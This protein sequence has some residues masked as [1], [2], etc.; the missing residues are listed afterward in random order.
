MPLDLKS[1]LNLP[2]T[3][4][5]MKANLPQR[6]PKRLEHWEAMGIY[7]RIREA[8]KGEPLYVLHDGPPYA[9]G[10]IH[11]GHALN[12]TLKDFIVKAQTMSGYDAPYV[13]GWDCHGLPIEIKVDDDLGRKKLEMDP[14]EVRD[15]CRKYADKYL[16]L[17]REQFKRLGVFGQWDNPYSTMTKQYESTVMETF[18]AFYEQGL[19]Y[20]GLKS[21]Y[22]CVHDKTALAEA[23]VEYEMH[24]SPSV[25]VRYPLT[26]DARKIDPALEGKKN[27]ATI[28]WTTTPWTLPASM[29]VTFAPNAEY[30]ALDTGEWIDIVA[31]E[32][33]QQTIA[34]C[35][36]GEPKEVA[37]FPGAKLEYATFAHPFLD[38]SVLGVL[39]D[40]VTM[41]T[42]TGAVHT[43]PAHGADDFQTG[44]KY[45][46]DLHCDVDEGG[47]LRNGLPEYKGQQVFKANPLIVELLKTRGVLLG[48]EKI[49]HSYPH[50]WRCH[51]PIIFRATEQWFI[52]M[53]GGLPGGTLRSRALEEIRKVKWDPAWGE[54]RISNMIATRPD[55]C[56]SRQRLWG[57]PIAVFQ[58][59]ACDAF[60]NEK[61]VNRVVVE[62]FAREGA[63]AWY[64]RAG[65]DILPAGTKCAKCGASKFRKEMDIID[66]WF[67]SGSSQAAVLGHEPDL[68]WPAD[69]YL[70]GGDQYRGW[71]NSSLLCAVGAKGGTPYRSAAT[72]GWTLDPQG[73][74]M[75][76]SLGNVVDPLDIIKELGAEIVRLWVASVDFREDVTA[77]PD[78]MRRVAD[79]YRKVRNTFRYILSNLA[80][81]D[82]QGDSVDFAEME[83]LDQYILLRA[84]ELTRDVRGHYGSF[85]FH[86]AYQ[87]LKDFCIVDLSAIYFDVLKDRLYTSAPK[88]VARRA[89][90][91]ALYRLGD[92]LVRLMAPTMCFTADEVW[93]YLPKPASSPASV[94]L[95][96]FPDA[97]ELT[98]DLPAGFDAAGL[99][100]EWLTLLNVRDEALKVLE[101]A[102]TDKHIGTGL[103]A[104][105]HVFAPE[106]LYSLLQRHRDQLRYLFIVSRV[107]LEKSEAANGDTGLLINVSK[108]AGEKCERCWNYSI[109]V[110]DD[111][112]YPTVCERCSA[113]LAEIEETA[114]AI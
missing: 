22:W 77:S 81:F 95:S 65:E 82:P 5:P 75:S 51:N 26:S 69:L 7:D 92:A 2:K 76:K 106:P 30:V 88:S 39:G 46:I 84:A 101:V 97:R 42:G 28:I 98:G 85:T 99:E 103:E 4:F 113:V 1:T 33:A 112:A 57:V 16:D 50:C 31:K 89:A 17:Q 110:G 3:D 32:L 25:W 61:S 9:N 63:D 109:H 41:D 78:F 43:A 87:R 19:V 38:R 11:L 71:F 74:A 6:E 64:K 18:F 105:L 56:I 52:S 86:K 100:S 62:L 111:K 108:A 48:Y 53:E 66:V 60:L 10:P 8:H 79:S 34:K 49:E 96:R 47:I 55:W 68:P 90:Q 29:A 14:M 94:H 23:E 58:C 13:P 102:R 80:G 72:N 20:K 67:E 24:S 45:N 27:V 54:E 114:G 73:R 93:E 36:L 15:A 12:K 107:V 37:L 59:E 35:T 21:V 91:T 40:Y 70:E 104:Q 83:P 44:V